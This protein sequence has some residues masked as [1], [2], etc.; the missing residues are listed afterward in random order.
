[1]NRNVIRQTVKTNRTFELVQQH[2]HF[3]HKSHDPKFLINPKSDQFAETRTRA[4]RKLQKPIPKHGTETKSKRDRRCDV[5]VYNFP[6]NFPV[7]LP[8]ETWDEPSSE[9]RDKL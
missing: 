6:G 9:H 5:R 4:S 8:R 7:N 3:K 2:N 1:M